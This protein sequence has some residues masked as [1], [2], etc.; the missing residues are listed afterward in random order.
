MSGD[1]HKGWYY[2]VFKIR[3]GRAGSGSGDIVDKDVWI[4]IGTMVDALQD[5]IHKDCEGVRA[6]VSVKKDRPPCNPMAT[7]CPRCRNVLAECD[8]CETGDS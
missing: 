2:T 5:S 3:P 8:F 4:P 7:Q 1:C 6:A